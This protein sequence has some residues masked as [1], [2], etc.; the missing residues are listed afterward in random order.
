VNPAGA[1]QQRDD[2]GTAVVEFVWLGLLMLVP[3]VYVMLAVSE[4]QQAAYGA[5]TASRA[6][7]RAFVLAPDTVSGHERAIGAARVALADQGVRQDAIDIDI[8]CSPNPDDC[9]APGSDVTVVV[10][11][12]QRL[13]LAPDGLGGA[14][15]A[16]TVDSS[17]T[18]PYGTFREARS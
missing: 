17:H 14:A 15:P 12:R 3:L 13:P 8:A 5:S 10:S 9:L 6:A 18:E 16:I 1:V 4:V 11:V 7:G 2:T